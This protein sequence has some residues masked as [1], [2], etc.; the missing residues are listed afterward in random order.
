[1]RPWHRAGCPRAPPTE[2][3]EEEGEEDEENEDAEEEQE[4]DEEDEEDEKVEEEEKEQEEEEEENGRG[5]PRERSGACG[6]RGEGAEPN[7]VL[8]VGDEAQA[9]VRFWVQGFGS[10]VWRVGFRGWRFGIRLKGLSFRICGR[11]CYRAI[12]ETNDNVIRAAGVGH[13]VDEACVSDSARKNQEV[14]CGEARHRPGR[15]ETGMDRSEEAKMGAREAR[16]TERQGGVRT[17]VDEL[18]RLLEQHGQGL[19]QHRSHE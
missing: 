4:E 10:R 5:K 12:P 8:V 13:G 11:V 1:M 14:A 16:G 17:R 2:E 15:E 9:S 6:G 18:L 3:E 19:S 7:G